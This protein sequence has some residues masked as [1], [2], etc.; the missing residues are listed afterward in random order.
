MAAA[1]IT[2]SDWEQIA[3]ALKQ[4]IQSAQ[5]QQNMKGKT[6]MIKEVYQRHERELLALLTKVQAQ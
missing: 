1:T 2:K 5:R 3:E 4:T 6:P